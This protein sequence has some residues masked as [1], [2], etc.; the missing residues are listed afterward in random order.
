MGVFL[1]LIRQGL[2]YIPFIVILPKLLGV[3]GIYFSQPAADILTII[4]CLLLIK[5]M[6]KKACENMRVKAEKKEGTADV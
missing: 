5:P 6:R 2:F 3:R 1:S 4:V